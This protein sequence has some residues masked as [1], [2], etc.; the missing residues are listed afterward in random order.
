MMPRPGFTRA[1]LALAALALF[2][3]FVLLALAQDAARTAALK[4]SAGL[5]TLDPT[6]LS[7]NAAE[8]PDPFPAPTA[9]SRPH[10]IVWSRVVKATLIPNTDPPRYE[11]KAVP[12]V[13]SPTSITDIFPTPEGSAFDP[14]LY[15]VVSHEPPASYTV[16]IVGNWRQLA[17]EKAW[18]LGRKAID[19]Q[20][21]VK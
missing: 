2:G 15:S 17:A 16:T 11:I 9:V 4:S 21:E 14:E 18:A 1:A 7:R 20:R 19:L 5:I 3:G 10:E 6:I 12:F 13:V 8:S